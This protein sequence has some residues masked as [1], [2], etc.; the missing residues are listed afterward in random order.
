MASCASGL[1]LAFLT[2]G[3][4][5]FA[6]GETLL[7][8]HSLPSG[9]CL[10]GSPAG[11][12]LEERENWEA[13]V[14][15]GLFMDLQ[16]GGWCYGDDRNATI[17]ACK[18]RAVTRLGSSLSYPP[19]ITLAPWKREIAKSFVYAFVPY[20]D[21][22]SFSGNATV[23]TLHF[24]GFRILRELSAAI[25]NIFSTSSSPPLSR[26]ILSGGSAGGSA[27]FY[28]I[29]T[30]AK[31]IKMDVS[32]AA[33]SRQRQVVAAGV[34]DSRS[35]TK[36][37]TS[38]PEREHE[39]AAKIEVLGVPNAGYFLKLN[40]FA[41]PDL[42]GHKMTNLFRLSNGYAALHQNCIH[43]KFA[44]DPDKCLYE[45][46][47]AEL[48]ETPLL[49]M[50]SKY[51]LSEIGST[52]GIEC[53]L[54]DWCGEEDGVSGGGGGGHERDGD[55]SGNA[56]SVNAGSGNAGVE[57]E[58]TR[59]QSSLLNRE[60]Q[61]TPP[62]GNMM[63]RKPCCTTGQ[64]EAVQNLWPLHRNAAPALFEKPE[65]GHF[66]LDCVVHGV[67]G[68]DPLDPRTTIHG[69][70][71]E[72]AIYAWAVDKFSVKLVD[73]R[74]WN[75][76]EKHKYC[77]YKTVETSTIAEQESNKYYSQENN[78]YYPQIAD[79]GWRG[80]I[81]EDDQQQ[82]TATTPP[83]TLT[84]FFFITLHSLFSDSSLMR[85]TTPAPSGLFSFFKQTGNKKVQ[86]NK[87]TRN[88]LMSSQHE[89]GEVQSEIF[90]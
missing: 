8:W 41:G 39:H 19:K 2:L 38:L 37:D 20:C 79:H 57:E 75:V 70:S 44:D 76:E 43:K 47:Y 88:N 25:A 12:Y 52:L 22:T 58:K 59:K 62:K 40:T 84:D 90:F 89:A 31:W 45:D 27:V 82:R 66:F 11:F 5:C 9:R 51:D 30:F 1:A 83:H 65:N 68:L 29:D 53:N 4:T 17:E 60:Q 63:N 18:Q 81:Y 80:D 86:E 74:S 69:Q 71:A 26:V 28:H 73:E 61:H 48:I 72:S 24:D 55:G 87:T 6:V 49:V 16:G 14:A 67:L 13:T 15:N 35:S 32:A 78:K 23:D 64:L 10:D 42:W 3:A 21:G 34:D 56:G 77:V 36:E 46:S 85:L 50:Q 54:D 7:E 33:A